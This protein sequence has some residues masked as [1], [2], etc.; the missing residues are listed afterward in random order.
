[1]NAQRAN[2][3]LAPVVL[4][5]KLACAAQAHA[6]DI[7]PKSS[8]SHTGSDDSSPFT[9]MTA[10]GYSYSQAGEIIACG[11]TDAQSAVA[12]WM[13][14]IPHKEIVLGPYTQVGISMVDN[15]WV[16]DWGTPL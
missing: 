14:D 12:A 6:Q 5:S 4:N 7:G 10:C 9:R 11:Q 13:S 8:C 3:G 16:V 2:A 1:L 15:Y